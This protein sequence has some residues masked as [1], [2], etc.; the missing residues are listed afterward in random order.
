MIEL[1]CRL[2]KEQK[3][4]EEG[5]RKL[6]IERISEKLARAELEKFEAGWSENDLV[7]TSRAF[8]LSH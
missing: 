1:E 2:D 6:E 5:G 3:Q 7:L 8:E 4:R